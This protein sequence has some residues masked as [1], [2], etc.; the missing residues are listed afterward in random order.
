M[1]GDR[2]IFICFGL[3]NSTRISPAREEVVSPP[4]Q[5]FIVRTLTNPQI[6][7]KSAL[8]SGLLIGL[9]INSQATDTIAT[10]RRSAAALPPVVI[11][12]Q[13]KS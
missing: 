5:A 9:A 6:V 2:G 13:V 4:N 1:Q 12:R 3:L 11:S 10:V 8:P 7:S